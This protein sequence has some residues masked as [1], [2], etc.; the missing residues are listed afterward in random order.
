MA[1]IVAAFGLGLGAV[2]G[3]VV[4]VVTGLCLS[5]VRTSGAI[6]V[7]AL[8]ASGI[9]MYKMKPSS[10]IEY[11]MTR[12]INFGFLLGFG[13]GVIPGPIFRYQ[14]TQSYTKFIDVE[15]PLAVDY[16]S[17]IPW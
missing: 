15:L 1:G 8:G 10:D 7:A 9:V 2:V 12:L 4:G 17:K 3:G 11:I 6:G 5:N 16:L 13:I 14:I